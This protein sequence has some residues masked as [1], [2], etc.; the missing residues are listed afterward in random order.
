[1]DIGI[2]VK[3]AIT[4]ASREIGKVN[5]LIAGRTGVGKS[6]LINEVFHGR[7]AE[8][9]QGKP[10]TMETRKIKKKGIPL[11]IYDTRGLELR[12]YEHIRDELVDLVRKKRAKQ[13]PKHHIHIAWICIAEDSR[14]V[15]EAEVWLHS[16]LAEHM[17]VLGVITKA[18]SDNG[19]KACVQKRLPETKQVVRVMAEP[20]FLDGGVEIPRVGLNDLVEATVGLIPEAFQQAWAASQKASLDLKKKSASKVVKVSA[21][22]AAAVAATP[23]PV[24]DAVP[25]VPIQI[26][27]LAKISNI[28]EIDLSRKFLR[29]L[30]FA[31]AGTT[32]NTMVGRLL[33]SRLL[34]LIPGVGSVAGSFIASATAATLT[35]TLGEAYITVLAKLFDCAGHEVPSTDEIAREV[36]DRMRRG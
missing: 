10:V 21:A 27:M 9:G 25:L 30:V 33:V 11:A 24:A 23:I 26:A 12:E 1:M 3:D 7:L 16:M 35:T 4:E 32:V 22:A 13:D 17:P 34:K 29:T 19:F 28:F 15:E 18:R 36:E 8:T 20:E 6:T 5:I 2:I 31:M 14:R